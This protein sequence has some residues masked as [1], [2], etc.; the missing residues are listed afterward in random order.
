MVNGEW[1]KNLFNTQHNNV[2]QKFIRTSKNNI[3]KHVTTVS[4]IFLDDIVDNYNDTYYRTI[5]MK[6]IGVK[7]LIHILN[8]MLS[9]QKHFW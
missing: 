1:H 8:T 6:S 7:N 3:F 5:E 2:A 4:K 9:L